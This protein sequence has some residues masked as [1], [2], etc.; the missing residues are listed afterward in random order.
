MP[1]A[2]VTI[3]AGFEANTY[4]ITFS[5]PNAT[6]PGTGSTVA[7]YGQAMPA[8]TPPART[9]YT[10]TG[11]YTATSGGT[12]YYNGDGTSAKVCDLTANTTLHAQWSINGYGLT[13][14]VE[15]STYGT[16]TATWTGQA[17]GVT[18]GTVN[19][20]DTVTI[21][22]FANTG[23]HFVK[24][25]VITENATL[26]NI[27]NATTT[28]TM[29]ASDVT[30]KASFAVNSYTVRFHMNEGS[31]TQMDDQLFSYHTSQNLS[32]NTYTRTGF[33]F[34][35]WSKS[36][37]ATTP[38]YTDG[39][40]IG[41][42][43]ALTP[44]HG[45]LIILY[46]VWDEIDYTLTIDLDDGSTPTE[47][48]LNYNDEYNLT[49][50]TRTGYIFSEWTI[51]TDESAT[52]ESTVD[53]YG[54]VVMGDGDT[55]VTAVWTPRTYSI[56]FNG[57][58]ATSG[59]TAS[60]TNLNYGQ[61]YQL[62]ANGFTRT[63][64]T[65]AGWN[66]QAN[67]SG[68]SFSGGATVNSLCTGEMGNTSITLYAQWT[69]NSND[70][71]I[72]VEP[73]AYGTATATWA[74]QSTGVT[75]GT[76]SYNTTVSFS[77]VANTGYHFVVWEVI[78]EN[79]TLGDIYSAVTTFTMPDADV[80]VKALFAVNTYTVS[81]NGN[82]ATGG[83]M[84][85]QEFSYFTPQNLKTNGYVRTGYLFL[86]WALSGDATVASFADGAELNSNNAL[87]NTHGA[88]VTIYAVWSKQTYTLTIDPD[89]ESATT[90]QSLAYGAT[91]MLPTVTKRGYTY[92]GWAVTEM[93]E[94]A[95]VQTSITGGNSL[96]MG[97]GD[98]TVTAQYVA[99]TYTITFNANGGSG[100][101][102]DM[103]CTYDVAVSLT[104]NAFTAVSGLNFDGWNTKADGTGTTYQN[105]QLVVNL[106]EGVTGDNSIV[107]YAQWSANS[108]TLTLTVESGAYGTATATWTGQTTGVTMGS[109]HYNDTVY[110]KAV[111]NTGYHFVEWSIVPGSGSA[112]IT[113]PTLSETSFSMPANNLTL[114]ANFAINQYRVAFS[115][116][117]GS[118]TAMETQYFTYNVTQA[119]SLNT[120]SRAGYTF[121]GWSLSAS[122]TVE[123]VD[124]AE[125]GSTNAVTEQHNVTVT[126]YAVWDE[127]SYVLTIDPDNGTAVTT[128][129]VEFGENF[130][131]P[132]G[133]ASP[134]KLGYTFSHWTAISAPGATIPATISYG[135][136]ITV[137]DSDVTAKAIYTANTYTIAF[138]ANGGTGS[139]SSIP[140]TYDVPVELPENEFTAPEGKV[141]S[142][143]NTAADGSGTAYNE[144]QEVS[145]LASAN[146]ATVTL[147]AQWIIGNYT[148]TFDP[149]L[150]SLL[151]G[152]PNKKTISFGS[153][154]LSGPSIS[155]TPVENYW[156][157]DPTL[158]LT[159]DGG[160]EVSF[161]FL[162]WYNG[163]EDELGNV[164][165]GTLVTT[166]SLVL[167]T[168]D[169]TVY[170]KW[171]ATG[172]DIEVFE[173]TISDAQ[174]IN[175]NHYDEAAIEALDDELVEL[176][177]ED[178]ALNQLEVLT[179]KTAITSA[180]EELEQSIIANDGAGPKINVFETKDKQ[181]SE[182]NDPAFGRYLDDEGQYNETTLISQ[183]ES[184]G[185]IS[186]VFPGKAH[187]TYYCY[188]NNESPLILVN[189]AD[190]AGTNGRVS[191]PTMA[192]I[193][194]IGT[195]AS[196]Q[197]RTRTGTVLSGWMQY[198]S[199]TPE[200]ATDRSNDYEILD[201]TVSS[202]YASKY[203][204]A[205]SACGGKSG[206]EYYG[207]SQYIVLRP[208]F[209]NIFSGNK[210]Y[211]LYTIT[212]Y[213]DSYESLVASQTSLA[214]AGE[215]GSFAT[216]SSIATSTNAD[217]TPNN[218]VTIYVEYKNVTGFDGTD[219]GGQIEGTNQPGGYLQ[220][221][222]KYSAEKKFQTVDYLY[223]IS[224]GATNDELLL[225]VPDAELATKYVAN[226]PQ[227]G[228][229][230]LGNF[231]QMV[232]SDSEV[233]AKYFEVYDQ[234]KSGGATEA[235]ATKLAGRAATALANAEIK[236]KLESGA[237]TA[238]MLR[239]PTSH[240]VPGEYYIW[241]QANASFMQTYCPAPTR[242]H[243]LVYVHL[244]DRWGNEFTSV[245]RR[246]YLDKSSPTFTNIVTGSITVNE[247]GGATIKH[248]KILTYT[249]LDTRHLV[250]VQP[251]SATVV[252]YSWNVADNTL[253]V[254]GLDPNLNSGMY[255]LYVEDHAGINNSTVIRCDSEGR[256]T[257]TICDEYM[258]QNY[259]PTTPEDFDEGVEPEDLQNETGTAEAPPVDTELSVMTIET[260][261]ADEAGGNTLEPNSELTVENREIEEVKAGNN[262]NFSYS[263]TLNEVYTVNLFTRPNRDYNITLKSTKGGSIRTYV[264][265]QFVAPQGGKLLIP[266]GSNVQVKIIT[267]SGYELSS[268]TLTDSAGT[269]TPLD[270]SYT[271]E[272]YDD[273]T[274]TAYFVESTAYNTVTVNN[275]TVN[276]KDTVKVSPYTQVIAIANKAPEGKVFAYWA[277]GGADGSIVSYDEVYM[278]Y[279]T[280]DVTLTAVYTDESVAVQPSIVMDPASASHIT[281]VN[282]KY[283]LAYSGKLTI[284]AGYTLVE[285]GL[286]LSNQ[287]SE[288]YTDENFVIGGSINGVNTVKIKGESL[289]EQGQFKINVNGVA[290]GATRAGRMYMVCKDAQNNEVLIYSSTWSVL[291]T[292]AD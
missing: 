193:D 286:V 210:Q 278:F 240:Q 264:N 222:T 120:Y 80:T 155:A 84:T 12:K 162:G 57:N 93:A 158:S 136:I 166:N 235:E 150:G 38:S 198:T 114:K 146:G 205:G 30:V 71:T 11:Y 106:C 44:T 64:H 112:S 119:L 111:A 89:N 96:V 238:A 180:Y 72:T 127:I 46:A 24:W 10:F 195:N 243:T 260:A 145:N 216:G 31:G 174:E 270:G 69:L 251:Y 135:T 122:G 39:Q 49:M 36:Q 291:T 197:K 284:P 103:I 275:G 116:N 171:A 68:T 253:T 173:T 139:M 212:A 262:V 269:V 73:S 83:T 128:Y 249:K 208:T 108:Y 34:L 77:A 63:G 183:V 137:G 99:N 267:Y 232:P 220:C 265:N 272:I 214:G 97:D 213:D 144:N 92:N 247:Y 95:T 47:I 6:T 90:T 13:L 62:S 86:G 242:E 176:F 154:F 20:N 75:S 125:I 76:V 230:N 98:T 19:Y 79:A 60:M 2:D 55:T 104:P 50:P 29:P 200:T 18:S 292:P 35:G 186:Y 280:A 58:G 221:Y 203:T 59:A 273:V 27:N 254:T 241:P 194:T 66:T 237:M 257:I 141:F 215:Y 78:T 105:G 61:D 33:E 9:G 1:A 285:F 256:F 234:A 28:F 88:T 147:Y 231:Y 117:G 107:L 53:E 26:G 5:S 218:T 45:D 113:D 290:P 245:V 42:E 252:D 160:A 268:L 132:E 178:H 32:L 8:I 228:Q 37:T 16:A 123:Y 109:V 259:Q 101:M 196:G 184:L 3:E 287:P 54:T 126:L 217:I 48:P 81:F 153:T 15:P 189:I 156:P 85:N 179:Y 246:D 159:F 43:N 274:I 14:T 91:Y 134:T 115:A 282:G 138:N 188:T 168:G 163:T 204:Y 149:T 7:T 283:S 140:A 131:I 224:G 233:V 248:I 244:A 225:T 110:L 22:A 209:D 201:M 190:V 169:R 226:D 281:T 102:N 207:Q 192:Q 164:T 100:S 277:S 271:A 121:I 279:A 82:Q 142:S 74:G 175:L 21:T 206:Y 258:P 211:A 266:G 51:S 219:C 187:Y 87:T 52:V 41:S 17:A 261:D 191:Y 223:R 143:W 152:E 157:S 23:Y 288:Y 70:L 177:G 255:V 239:N 118:G 133:Q 202:P 56:Y 40:S 172:N 185:D 289:T 151:S 148:L 4:T 182:L 181:L 199:D 130:T 167:T 161:Q 170:A 124:G 94:T 250:N 276:G 227:F 129:D 236:A 229:T 263:F 67:G 165:Y 25:E 65:F